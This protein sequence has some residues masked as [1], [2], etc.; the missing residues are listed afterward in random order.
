VF[1]IWIVEWNKIAEENKSEVFLKFCALN[2]IMNLVLDTDFI[3][4]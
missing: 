3:R 2:F 1:K 4:I